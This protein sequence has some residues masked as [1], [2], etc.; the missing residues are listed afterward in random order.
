MF[1]MV[2]GNGLNNMEDRFHPD[3]LD[4][5]IPTIVHPL[6]AR[7]QNYNF[8]PPTIHAGPDTTITASTIRLTGSAIPPLLVKATPIAANGIDTVPYKIASW[9][10]DP[11][12]G[13]PLSPDHFP[14]IPSTTVTGSEGIYVFN[15]KTTDN[16]TGTQ[17]VDVTVT[18]KRPADT[19][20]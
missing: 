17:S 12:K 8:S 9:A 1:R 13:P 14:A 15:L 11:G 20:K 4:I 18:V 7:F 10:R 5:L 6:T 2:L 16:N 19:K 3:A